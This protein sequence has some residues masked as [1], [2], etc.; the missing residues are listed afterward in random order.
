MGGWGGG[1]FL[2][3]SPAD[4]PENQVTVPPLLSIHVLCIV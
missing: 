2:E 4:D 3:E 1:G